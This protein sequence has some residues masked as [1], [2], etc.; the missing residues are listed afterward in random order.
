MRRW[1]AG[2]LTLTAVSVLDLAWAQDPLT[3][4]K[5][6]AIRAARIEGA[7]EGMNTAASALEKRCASIQDAGRIQ[8]VAALLGEAKALNQK[9]AAAQLASEVLDKPL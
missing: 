2:A 6:W 7:S 4:D 8:Q 1:T 9:V 3:D 5:A